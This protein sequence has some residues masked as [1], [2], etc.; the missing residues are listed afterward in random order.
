MG[1]GRRSDCDILSRPPTTTGPRVLWGTEE[2]GEYLRVHRLTAWRWIKKRGLPA[3]QGYK[4]KWF[5]TTSLID[6][7]IVTLRQIQLERKK[8]KNV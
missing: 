7:W 4:G 6:I 2:I 3:A 5:S 8:T 1:M